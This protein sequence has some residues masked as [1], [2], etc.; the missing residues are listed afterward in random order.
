MTKG[1]SVNT[2]TGITTMQYVNTFLVSTT[3]Q[4]VADEA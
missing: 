1:A 2:S 3:A 4:D